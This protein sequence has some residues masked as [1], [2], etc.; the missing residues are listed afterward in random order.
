MP[1]RMCYWAGLGGLAACVFGGLVVVGLPR[2]FHASTAPSCNASRLDF[3]CV[4][5]RYLPHVG[6]VTIIMNDYPIVKYL[7]IAVLGLFV[8]TSK[9]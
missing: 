3:W 6:R 1:L 7:L 4:L 9:E 2:L 5:R 8:V